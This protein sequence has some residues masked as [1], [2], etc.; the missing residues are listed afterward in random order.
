M[1]QRVCGRTFLAGYSNLSI[2]RLIYV[3]NTSR[4]TNFYRSL[5]TRP[6]SSIPNP[7][8]P[9]NSTKG[10]GMT[11]SLLS[12][13]SGIIS[14]TEGSWRKFLAWLRTILMGRQ[15]RKFRMEDA[16]AIFSWFSLGT[17][18]FILAGTTTAVSMVVAGA[19]SSKFQGMLCLSDSIAY[20]DIDN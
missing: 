12:T 4:P 18:F 5:P 9:T 6:F 3:K 10:N 15:R 1:I 14:N 19:N 8:N 2:S 17:S 20:S 11:E 7:N 13:S 16:L